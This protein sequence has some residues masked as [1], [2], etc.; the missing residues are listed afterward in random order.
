[1]SQLKSFYTCKNTWWPTDLVDIKILE[2]IVILLQNVNL[3]YL[4]SQNTSKHC[5][6]V[7][8]A[9]SLKEWKGT[10]TYNRKRYFGFHYLIAAKHGIR[11]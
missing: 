8:V 7:M 4:L 3:M 1:M 6:I 11:I 5:Q 2:Q 9:K 10:D